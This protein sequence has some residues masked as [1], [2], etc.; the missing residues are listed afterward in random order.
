VDGVRF[1]EGYRGYVLV[2]ILQALGAYGYRGFF[3]RK[4]RFLESVPY[5]ARNLAGLLEAGLPVAL[6]EVER[7]LERVV[8]DWAGR[9]TSTGAPPGLTVHVRSF[10]YRQGLPPD[11]TG[12]GGGHVFDCRAI[13]NPG[14]RPE[15]AL[16]SGRDPSVA[17]FLESA[18]ET[19]EF[20]GHA[21]SIVD[22]HVASFR[23]RGFSY[24]SVAFGCTGGQH[25]S[26]Y[27]AER[28]AEHLRERFP[29]VTV[30]LEH[31]EQAKWG[32]DGGGEGGGA[33]G[34]AGGASGDAAGGASGGGG[35]SA[36][37][38]APGDARE[39]GAAPARGSARPQ[40]SARDAP[41]TR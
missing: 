34:G 3:E 11:E 10:S 9:P 1:L 39:R 25:R 6:P 24:L 14:R 32:G 21:A 31:G 23:E 20:W 26:V 2:R 33:V 29:D 19:A 36:S 41:W 5:A 4:A 27:F 40:T 8:E 18:P 35:A 12:H 28:L 7:V 13:P 16:V 22:A 30:K 15:F 38:A 17:A 37:G